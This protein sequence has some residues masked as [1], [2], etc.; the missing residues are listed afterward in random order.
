[1]ATGAARSSACRSARR[2]PRPSGP[3]SCE[4]SRDDSLRG[5]KLV[6]SDAHEGLKAAITKVLKATWQRCRVHSGA[7]RRVAKRL[8]RN[9]LAH[10]GEQERGVVAA[11]IGTAFAQTDADAAHKQWRQIG[12]QLRPKVKKL[13]EIMDDAESDVLAYNDLPAAHRATP[14]STDRIERVNGEIKRRTDVIGIFPKDEA[15]A[16]GIGTILCNRTMTGPFSAGV[17]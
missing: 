1:M 13:A 9:V 17:I 12:D 15:V 3:T 14:H 6:I 16:R 8:T 11:F 2:K 7:Q 10:A 4:P 5:A